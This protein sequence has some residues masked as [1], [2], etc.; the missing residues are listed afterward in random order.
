MKAWV[1]GTLTDFEK[2]QVHLLSHS[3]SRGSA[4]F[5]VMEIVS[6]DGGPA[7]FCMHEH[8]ERFFASAHATYMDLPIT[9]PELEDAL[10]MTAKANAIERGIVKIYAYYPAIG[11]GTLPTSTTIDIAVF[12][13]GYEHMGIVPDDLGLPV[14]A[15][16]S[17]FRKL[18][19][20]TTAVHAKIVGNYVN[21]F[22]AKNEMR[23]LGYDEAILLDTHGF[24]AEGPT[25]NI[26]FIRGKTIET[27]T[28]ESVLPGITRAV[29]MN[30]LSDMDYSVRETHILP[31][32]LIEFEE[33]F[34]SGTLNHVQ[35]IRALSGRA[36]TCPGPVTG[37]VQ[38]Q[39]MHVLS[40]R[41]PRYQAHLRLIA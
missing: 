7:F 23:S 19:P 25:S 21:G 33:A 27:P 8:L 16:I 4:I 5:E 2:A 26:F 11:L 35:P 9:L 3:F 34:F 12:C 37:A 28:T 40:G 22:L 38:N 13:L 17:T 29:L 32:E 31:E 18:D 39:M 20:H 6:T 36:L 24:I 15:G 30:V 14:T 41:E 10:M 1:N